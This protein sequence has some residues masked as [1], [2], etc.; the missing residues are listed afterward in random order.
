MRR[1]ELCE[2]MRCDGIS[3]KTDR[4]YNRSNGWMGMHL[5]STS[6]DV[7][8]VM[9]CPSFEDGCRQRK[10]GWQVDRKKGAP[11]VGID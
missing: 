8:T 1:R 6:A 5:G 7:E 11:L 4:R 3:Q 10:K 2:G 9:A